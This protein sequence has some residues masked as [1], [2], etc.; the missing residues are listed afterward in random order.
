AGTIADGGANIRFPA[1]DASCPGAAGDPGLGPLQDNGGPVL[2]LAP[3]ASGAAIDA[4]TVAGCPA[5]DAR[6]ATRPVGAACDAGAY[7]LTPP[8]AT[9]GGAQ[10]AA[11][12]ITFSATVDPHGPAA[13]VRFDYGRT[14]S[15][16]SS[17][18]ASPLAT[19]FGGRPVSVLV[20]GLPSGT[21][22]HYRVAAATAD[23]TVAGAD[24]TFTTGTTG[25]GGTDRT[26]PK[27]TKLA[28]SKSRFAVTG[29]PSAPPTFRHGK[30]H[31]TTLRLKLSENA[32]VRLS[33]LVK[34]TVKKKGKRVIR[35]VSKG[36]LQRSL[37]AGSRTIAVSGWIGR[38]A[39]APGSYHLTVLATDGA[40]NRS[41][42]ATLS[43]TI[44]H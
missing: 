27:L 2:T 34:T 14:T 31:G 25:T 19:G 29:K 6:G 30:A 9:T 22:I 24:A 3:S 10:P 13:T 36:T 35:Y 21:V 12:G 38:K 20:A 15:Y 43:F 42:L 26:P 17:I 40:K 37:K 28:L 7:E 1:A 44:V 18:A 11:A 32:T 23:G 39:L 16:G 5:T 8:S 41:K 4:A 33:F